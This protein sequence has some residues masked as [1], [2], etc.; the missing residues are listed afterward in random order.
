[1]KSSTKDKVQGELGKAYGI[2]EKAVGKL[3][4]NSKLTAKG[5]AEIMEGKI[6]SKVGD[7]KKSVSK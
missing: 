4:D 6:Q 5:Q 1:M 3:T 7:I 2:G